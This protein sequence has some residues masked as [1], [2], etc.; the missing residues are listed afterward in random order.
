MKKILLLLSSILIINFYACSSE[1]DDV[2]E[3]TDD[4]ASLNVWEGP[5]KV[6]SKADGADYTQESN[7]DRLTS[8]VWITR[9]NGGQIFNI[10]KESSADKGDSPSGTLWSIGTLDN[11]EN[12]TFK[13]FRLAVGQPKDVVGK[14]LVLYLVGDD[15]YLTVKFTSWS[16]GQKGGFAY[17]RTTQ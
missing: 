5:I 7:Q 8:N 6:F 13:T 12:L 14:N 3:I 1:K 4:I 10:A 17:E 11:I 15:I 2:M 9:G 16:Q